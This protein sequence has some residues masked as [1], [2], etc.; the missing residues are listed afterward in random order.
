MTDVDVRVLFN[1]DDIAFRLAWYDRF[2]DTLSVDSL[3]ARE[4][5]YGADDTYPAFFPGGERVRGWFAD[6][7]EVM[8]PVASALGRYEKPAAS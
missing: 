8:L 2:A 7:A 6:A 3:L 1:R 4:Q 5:G